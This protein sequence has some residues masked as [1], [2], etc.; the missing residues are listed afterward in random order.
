MSIPNFKIFYYDYSKNIISYD[1]E[2]KTFEMTLSPHTGV[3]SFYLTKTFQLK[4]NEID[5]MT[6]EEHDKFIKSQCVKYSELIIEWRNMILE[7][8]KSKFKFDYFDNSFKLKEHNNEIYYRTHN[9]NVKT[10]FKRL[11]KKQGNY[12]Y[13]DFD[14]ILY[15]EYKW[16]DNCKNCG[17][18]YLDKKGL[19]KNTYGYDFKMSYPTDMASIKFQMPTKR[20]TEKIINSLPEQSRYVSFGIYRVKIEC[21]D[22]DFKK[23]FMINEKH[24]YTSYSLKFAINLRNKFKIK[25]NLI[26][27]NKPNAYIYDRKDLISGNKVFGNWYYTLKQMKE[28]MP[29]NGIIKLLSSAGW[30]HLNECKVLYKT[31]EQ[32]VE[33][34]NSGVKISHCSENMDYVILDMYKKETTIYK[35]IKTNE[36]VYDLNLRL[37]PFITSFSRVKMGNLIHKNNLYN[38]VL[39]IQTDSITFY[40]DIN[41]KIPGFIYD[42]K[43]SGDI[44]FNHLNDYEKLPE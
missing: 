21:E 28:D 38:E 16:F 41:L 26:M 19:Q 17:L 43:I 33:M 42:E 29:T 12:I 39:R 10:F 14:S 15:D 36:P 31:E 35:L 4:K 2:T 23:V 24:Y 13:D 5:K 3:N 11:T 25:I 22:K 32:L 1:Y 18:M 40:N 30:G 34:I 7:Y 27:D 20:G 9:R 37:L 44:N 6:D 8:K